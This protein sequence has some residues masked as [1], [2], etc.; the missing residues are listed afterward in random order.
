MPSIADTN[1][2]DIINYIGGEI[3]TATHLA[4]AFGL[5]SLEKKYI[6]YIH[7]EPNL[8]RALTIRVENFLMGHG[9]VSIKFYGNWVTDWEGV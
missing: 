2:G 1:G 5:F 6:F 3:G 4:I 8:L 7:Y 9:I